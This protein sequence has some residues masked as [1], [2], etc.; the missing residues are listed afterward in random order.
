MTYRFRVGVKSL[1]QPLTGL[2]NIG[3]NHACLLLNTDLFEYGANDEKSYER[4][5][6]VGRDSSF[7]WDELGEALNGTTYISPDQ[8]ET[9]IINNDKWSK[10]HYNFLFHNCHDFVRFCLDR[11]GCPQSMITKIGP[12]FKRQYKKNTVQIRSILGDKNL[13]IKG[14]KIENQTEIILYQAHGGESQTFIPNYNFDLTVTFVKGKYAI[15]VRW[16]EA[17]NGTVIQIWEQNNTLSQKFILLEHSSGYVSIHSAIN[18]MFVIDVEGACTDDYTKIQ[19]YQYNGSNAQ[20]FK[21]V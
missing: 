20:L 12:C 8:L 3:Y 7:D 11:I 19:L 21:L 9:A 15:D 6:E 4:H 16:G 2:R 18:P 1:S 10:G 14:N 13:D 5:K 17:K